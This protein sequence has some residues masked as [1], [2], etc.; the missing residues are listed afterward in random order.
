MKKQI[1]CS[2]KKQITTLNSY[3]TKEAYSWIVNKI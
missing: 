3:I 2:Q 1:N